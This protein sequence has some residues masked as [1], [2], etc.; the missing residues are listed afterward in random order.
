MV[1]DYQ[2]ATNIISL[3]SKL[4]WGQRLKCKNPCFWRKIKSMAN[5]PLSILK[6]PFQ[7]AVR[8]LKDNKLIYIWLLRLINVMD[9]FKIISL[10]Y[11]KW[12]IV[13]STPLNRCLKHICQKISNIFMWFSKL[14]NFWETFTPLCRIFYD[15][16]L[17]KIIKIV[18]IKV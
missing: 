5:W 17:M 1:N 8:Y 3:V 9:A 18:K 11:S 6:I 12:K 14:N 15:I 13:F 2:F 10:L 4:Y 7:I 16:F